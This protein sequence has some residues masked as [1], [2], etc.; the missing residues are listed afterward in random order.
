MKPEPTEAE[1]KAELAE[2]ATPEPTE[3]EV[4]PELAEMVKP[5]L[6]SLASSSKLSKSEAPKLL[7]VTRE[8]LEAA[9]EAELAQLDIPVERGHEGDSHRQ[10]PLSFIGTTVS[11]VPTRVANKRPRL[12]GLSSRP[13]PS[14][15]PTVS[16][17]V[18]A[19]GSP[20]AFV[21][22]NLTFDERQEQLG[23]TTLRD[24]HNPSFI[25]RRG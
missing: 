6:L 14:S 1:V 23:P 10:S 25:L 11:T 17:H 20:A 5:E 2:E 13:V 19:L 15:T 22:Q 4:T 7:T 24:P 16:Y 9:A 8:A 12:S 3:A 21:D 18:T